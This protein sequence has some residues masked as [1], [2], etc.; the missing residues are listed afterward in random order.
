MA[1]KISDCAGA[2]V[3]SALT[4]EKGK[5]SKNQITWTV[6]Y[7]NESIWCNTEKELL[8]ILRKITMVQLHGQEYKTWEAGKGGWRKNSEEK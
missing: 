2:R 6:H 1:K 8:S 7:K 3:H 5:K 4:K